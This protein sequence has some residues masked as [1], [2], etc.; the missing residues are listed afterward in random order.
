MSTD[1][2]RLEL[3]LCKTLFLPRVCYIIDERLPSLVACLLG[4]HERNDEPH[5]VVCFGSRLFIQRE[6]FRPESIIQINL[7]SL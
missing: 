7:I 5:D 3:L 2:V 1:N 6:A 4:I